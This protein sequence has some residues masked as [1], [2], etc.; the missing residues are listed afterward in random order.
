MLKKFIAIQLPFE[1]KNYVIFK[2]GIFHLEV[3]NYRFLSQVEN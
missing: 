1:L 2:E 3:A